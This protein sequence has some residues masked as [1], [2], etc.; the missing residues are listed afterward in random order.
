M[1]QVIGGDIGGTHC[2]LL[3]AQVDGNRIDIQYEQTY[4]GRDFTEFEA[5]LQHFIEQTEASVEAACFAVAGPVK[6]NRV[7]LTNLPWTLDA[8]QLASRFGIPRICLI[9]DFEAN[10]YSL[11]VLTEEDYLTLQTGTPSGGGNRVLIGAGT[12]LGMALV[13]GEGVRMAVRAS[14]G[15]HMDFAPLNEEQD[16][17]LNFLRRDA[18]R[19]SY[20]YVLSGPGLVRLYRY[21]AWRDG[22]S[23]KDVMQSDDPPAAVSQ[24][25]ISN[26]DPIASSA[27]ALFFQIYGSC[28]ANLALVGLA[29]D[30]VY[31]AGGIAAKLSTALQQSDFI[32]RFNDKPPMSHLLQAMP[33]KLVINPRVGLL[34]AVWYAVNGAVGNR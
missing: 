32:D 1:T 33:V 9:N 7:R 8:T 20:E 14:E 22:A 29:T 5:V 23:D 30:G 25:A 31:L 12:G 27:V 10:G 15:G 13:S 4:S 6:S 19:V 24:R 21:C 2:R 16:E 18:G 11:S 17:L 26:E 34:G 3:M 28:A